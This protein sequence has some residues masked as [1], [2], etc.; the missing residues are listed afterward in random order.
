MVDGVVVVDAAAS[1][2]I[3]ILVVLYLLVAM[4]LNPSLRMGFP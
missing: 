3:L 2:V 4:G 1:G